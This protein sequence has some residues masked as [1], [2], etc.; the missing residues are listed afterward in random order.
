MSEQET[1]EA[2]TTRK[3]D[4][5]IRYYFIDRGNEDNLPMN[6]A[7][8]DFEEYI[9]APIAQYVMEEYVNGSAVAAIE[10]ILGNEERPLTKEETEE[11]AR[12]IGFAVLHVF[13]D[14][15]DP[16]V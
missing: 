4:A 16:E 7:M 9:Y 8:Q 3:G 10:A 13:R 12:T 15:F 6:E 5:F 11:A 1:P 14:G 2:E